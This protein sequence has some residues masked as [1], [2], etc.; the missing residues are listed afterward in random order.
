MDVSDRIRNARMLK[1]VTQEQVAAQAGMHV[2]QYNAYE[3][4]RSRPAPAT[5]QR[6]AAAL[7]T[8]PAALLGATQRTDSITEDTG[9]KR[10]DLISSLRAR[11]R[12]DLAA[13]LGLDPG[14]IGIRIEILDSEGAA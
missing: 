4:A 2:T 9:G 3:R 12:E 13:Q 11:F 6:V 7:G 5:L 1:G 14:V 10:P 8:T